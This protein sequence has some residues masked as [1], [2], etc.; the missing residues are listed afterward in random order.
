MLGKDRRNDRRLTFRLVRSVNGI[1][2]RT[3]SCFAQLIKDIVCWIVPSLEQRG[4]SCRH[5]VAAVRVSGN[6][7]LDRDE[8]LAMQGSGNGWRSFR[9]SPS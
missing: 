3:I 8:N 9:T 6:V 1:G 7:S 2:S 4:L 5:P